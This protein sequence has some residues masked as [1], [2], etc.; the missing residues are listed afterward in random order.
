MH[1]WVQGKVFFFCLFFVS[2]P[3]AL[4]AGSK[5]WTALEML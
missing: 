4:G 5:H 2:A 3:V 1:R